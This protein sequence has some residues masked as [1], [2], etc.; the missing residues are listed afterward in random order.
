LK[1]SKIALLITLL[2]FLLAG[3]EAPKQESIDTYRIKQIMASYYGNINEFTTANENQKEVTDFS[4]L[5]KHLEDTEKATRTLY[6][7]EAQSL[8]RADLIHDPKGMR[9]LSFAWGEGDLKY[10]LQLPGDEKRWVMETFS[11]TTMTTY[12]ISYLINLPA[13][14]I[15]NI[16]LDIEIAKNADSFEKLGN[17]VLKGT[18]YFFIA[19]D[20]FY[21][22]LGLI[23]A[24]VMLPIGFVIALL[25]SPIQTFLDIIPVIVDLVKTFYYA[26]KHLFY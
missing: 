7:M 16:R 1:K 14:L 5:L 10:H 8:S 15:A 18:S 23:I 9:K 19:L 3:C 4:S 22:L 6:I 20:V 2:T 13:K 24:L 25:T 12:N 11:A 21:A 17:V 26:V